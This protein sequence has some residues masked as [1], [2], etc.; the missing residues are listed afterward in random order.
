[1]GLKPLCTIQHET[2]QERNGKHSQGFACP[3]TLHDDEP[4]RTKTRNELTPKPTPVEA[5]LRRLLDRHQ[6]LWRESPASGTGAR[7]TAS[8]S[9]LSVSLRDLT[10]C[11]GHVVELSK[12]TWLY[13]PAYMETKPEITPIL[14]SK[15]EGVHEC[16][17]LA[18]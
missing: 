7:L 4:K 17:S 15:K 12:S 16:A 6:K 3:V 8:S 11:V 18:S 2:S 13:H 5:R 10:D 14:V 1:M 9:H